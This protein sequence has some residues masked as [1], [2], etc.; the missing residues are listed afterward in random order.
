MDSDLMTH[1]F[2]PNDS[3]P[4]ASANDD[5]EC[6]AAEWPDVHHPVALDCLLYPMAVVAVAVL[7]FVGFL[8]RHHMCL[9]ISIS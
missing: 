9:L 7:L 4:A 1:W 6:D 2:L 5:S 8:H 3:T